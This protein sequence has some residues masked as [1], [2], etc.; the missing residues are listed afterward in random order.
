MTELQKRLEAAM[1]KLCK[2]RSLL[3]GWQLGTRQKGEPDCDAVRDHR[4]L[5]ILLR[6]EVSALTSA[7]IGKGIITREE[8]EHALLT[9][10]MLLD[11]DFERRF[12]GVTATEHGLEMD[13]RKINELGW[14]NNWKR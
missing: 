8:W 3:A 1:Q 9:E 10:C 14:M 4:E 11:A 13:I 5:T 12:P 2:W 6:A 7:L